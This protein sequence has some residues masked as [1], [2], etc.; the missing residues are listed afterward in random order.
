M[1][2]LGVG[3]ELRG[4]DAAGVLVARAVGHAKLPGVHAIDGGTAP[5]NF[6]SDVKKLAP[7]HLVIVDAAQLGGTPPSPGAVALLDAPQAG[8]TGF[9]THALPLGVI[10]AYLSAET[11]CHV[12]IV[13]IQSKNAGMGDEMSEEVARAVRNVTEALKTALQE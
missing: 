2:V 1:V 11:G 5:E 3:S 6:T 13:A 10:A 12:T 8:A 9:G 7:T 4:D